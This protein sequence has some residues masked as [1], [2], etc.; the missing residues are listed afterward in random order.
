MICSTLLLSTVPK[1]LAKMFPGHPV[2][3][4]RDMRNRELARME[5]RGD[6]APIG[7]SRDDD[8]I[9]AKII[10]ASKQLADTINEAGLSPFTPPTVK[11]IQ[12]VVADFYGVTVF[13]MISERRDRAIAMPRQVAMFLCRTMTGKSLPRIG[14]MFLRDHTTIIHAVEKIGK[15]RRSDSDLEADLDALQAMLS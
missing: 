2:E 3:K 7:K 6:G 4:L 15:Q 14:R 12:E 11:R 10:A 8:I 1:D 9:R 13:D 5:K